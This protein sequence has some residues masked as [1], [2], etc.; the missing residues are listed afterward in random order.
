MSQV[1]LGS[2]LV[3]PGTTIIDTIYTALPFDSDRAVVRVLKKVATTR[4]GSNIS[5]VFPRQWVL[6]D[7]GVYQNTGSVFLGAYAFPLT[8]RIGFDGARL[9]KSLL[10]IDAIWKCRSM[11]PIKQCDR[12]IKIGGDFSESAIE[13]IANQL[14]ASWVV[15]GKCWKNRKMETIPQS[16]GL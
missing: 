9:E 3:V 13:G 1:E 11:K 10:L 5:R 8:V 15:H 2:K 12:T 6:I 16:W 14:V 7:K 4:N